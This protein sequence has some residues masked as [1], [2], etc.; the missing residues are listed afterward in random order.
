MDRGQP[1]RHQLV[2]HLLAV[3][4][5]TSAPMRGPPSG[6]VGGRTRAARPMQTDA[7]MPCGFAAIQLLCWNPL[8]VCQR[9]IGGLAVFYSEPR[10][11][12]SGLPRGVSACSA[13]M[14]NPQ[15]KR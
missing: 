2:T 12:G 4:N 13:A 10:P 8:V 3:R 11:S 6:H 9:S 14:T 7:I 1:E 5:V 15:I